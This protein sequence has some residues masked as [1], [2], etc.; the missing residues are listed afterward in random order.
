VSAQNFP[1]A[2]CHAYST[3]FLQVYPP[4]QTTPIY[5]PYTSTACAKPVH[6]LTV[7]V[8]KAGASG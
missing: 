7:D 1:A 3:T 2:R 4:N 8:V 5:V 6:L